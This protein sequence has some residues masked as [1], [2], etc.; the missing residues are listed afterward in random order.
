MNND[1]VMADRGPGDMQTPVQM[2]SKYDPEKR[3]K[4]ISE[5]VN[6]IARIQAIEGVPLMYRSTVDEMVE[7]LFRARMR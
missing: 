5:L 3:A 4:E 2:G 7:M 6:P 1:N